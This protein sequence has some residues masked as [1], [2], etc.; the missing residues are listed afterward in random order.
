MTEMDIMLTL[1]AMVM[2]ISLV[3]LYEDLNQG[4]LRAGEEVDPRARNFPLV[5]MLG[6]AHSASIGDP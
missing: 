1:L 6:L 3:V 4:R 2:A 5:L